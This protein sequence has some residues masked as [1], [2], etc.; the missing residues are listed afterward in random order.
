MITVL[1]L[2]LP[3]PPPP[4]SLTLQ[5][6]GKELG[7]RLLQQSTLNATHDKRFVVD[8][9]KDQTVPL[10]LHWASSM[11]GNIKLTPG[12]VDY[13]L[14]LQNSEG[15]I[16]LLTGY[17]LLPFPTLFFSLDVFSAFLCPAFGSKQLASAGT[18]PTLLPDVRF[19]LASEGPGKRVGRSV[20][21][22]SVSKPCASEACL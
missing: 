18:S 9:T 10:P 12:R 7:V 2:L 21:A 16:V 15:M 1:E 13:F 8:D 11:A 14:L 5:E 3:P 4:S 6:R 19:T 20:R 17:S 22:R